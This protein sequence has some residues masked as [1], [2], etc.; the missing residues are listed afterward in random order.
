MRTEGWVGVDQEGARHVD[1]RAGSRSWIRSTPGA[2]KVPREDGGWG[3]ES[4]EECVGSWARPCRV[5]GKGFGQ[6]TSSAQN[7]LT[8]SHSLRTTVSWW[9]D[10]VLNQRRHAG[11]S[12][13]LILEASIWTVITNISNFRRA[14]D[15][16]DQSL[17]VTSKSPS[18][19][20]D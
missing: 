14:H 12:L 3:A 18:G 10:I 7:L 11:V 4:Q 19:P 13:H 1:Q 9:W 2:L 16:C 17:T 6:W 15:G 8:A 20:R 5:Q